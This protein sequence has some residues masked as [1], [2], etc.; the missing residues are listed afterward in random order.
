M[1][2]IN[3]NRANYEEYF[4]LYTDNELN[5][6]ERRA[7][8]EFVLQNPDLE[9]EFKML[10]RST[11]KPEKGV[12]FRNKEALMQFNDVVHSANY[13]EFFL[14]YAD[15]ELSNQQKAQV[16]QFVYDHPQYQSAFEF[17][18]EIRL[19]PDSDVLFL[20]K[21]RLYRHER[22]RPIAIRWWKVA[23]AAMVLLITG[24]VWMNNNQHLQPSDEIVQGVNQQQPVKNPT[25][26]QGNNKDLNPIDKQEVRGKEPIARQHGINL[27]KKATNAGTEY[28]MAKKST[29]ET[30][31]ARENNLAHQKLTAKITRPELKRISF[32]TVKTG[33]EAGTSTAPDKIDASL[34]NNISNMVID[35]PAIKTDDTKSSNIDRED[36]L[37]AS[38]TS[39]ENFSWPTFPLIASPHFAGFI[40]KLRA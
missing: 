30:K 34:A 10:Q 35:Q 12:A 18:Q 5:A 32:S 20:H 19:T 16:E 39:A 17:L 22:V 21:E 38:N 23:A 26:E 8:E 4:L 27:G 31:A 25:K 37:F 33:Q 7:V 6:A 15:N 36:I 29:K 28:T 2:M 14:L 24:L 9:Y 11:L 13:E 1:K 3:I 40:E